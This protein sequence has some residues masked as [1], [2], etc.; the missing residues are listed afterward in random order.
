MKNI[1]LGLKNVFKTCLKNPLFNLLLLSGLATTSNAQCTI[2]LT[3]SGLNT[4]SV[5]CSGNSVTIT[6]DAISNYSWSPGNSISAALIVSPTVTT[7]YT[8]SAMSAANCPS[9]AVVTV[10][11]V[12]TPTLAPTATPSMICEGKSAVL[13]ATGAAGTTYTW[14]GGSA[15]ANT[16]TYLVTP[17]AGI[18]NFTV[19]RAI[20]GCTS[21]AQRILIVNALPTV[22]AIVSPTIVCAGKP[23]QV[24][25]A[26][27]QTYTWTSPGNPPS[28]A[29]FTFGGATAQVFPPVNT[30]YTVAAHDGTCV[31]T[32]T[33]ELLTNPNPT[34]TASATPSTIC[35]GNSV[36]INAFGSNNFTI[37]SSSNPNQT[38]TSVPFTQTLTQATSYA[39]TGVNS[40]NCY[41][42]YNQIVVV[43]PIPTITASIVGTKTMVCSGGSTSIGANSGSGGFA[44]HSYTWST[45]AL[46]PTTVVNPASSVTGPVVYTV[47]GT[48][49]ITTCQSEATVAVAVFIPTI[50][51][52]GPTATC[53]GKGLSLFA[54]GGTG[55]QAYKWYTVPGSSSPTSTNSG[56]TIGSLTATA[57]YTLVASTSTGSAQNC[58]T[59]RTIDVSIYFNPTITAVAQRTPICSGESVDLTADGGVS[60]VWNTG[61]VGQVVAVS[62]T[63]NTNYTVTGQ[64]ANSCENTMTVQVKVS[65][66]VGVGELNAVNIGLN[67]YPNPSNGEFVIKSA[68]NLKLTLVNDLGQ[69]IRSIELSGAN[70]YKVSV[71]DLSKG[72]YFLSGEKDNQQIRQKIVVAK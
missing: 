64:D 49:T 56:L 21:T 43:S 15:S 44:V 50:S 10:S 25:V 2:N 72:I 20:S 42:T 17:P 28:V 23:A 63:V 67:V 38:L 5:L 51:V 59:T 58:I 14:T 27:G 31:N 34:I 18:N 33:V 9:T 70:D 55:G 45:G 36:T 24:T 41:T 11:V 12:L 7:T 29:S 1:Y 46:T 16:N 3:V 48:N 71:S 60:Y 52:T 68:G 4:N 54:N 66:C 62:P 19:T 40:F 26:G 47:S 8:L 61:D 32:T 30:I 37:V 39:I 35:S 69:L 65:A 22:F 57:Q 6:S 13:T 53:I